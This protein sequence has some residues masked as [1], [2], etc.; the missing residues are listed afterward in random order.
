MNNPDLIRFMQDLVSNPERLMRYKQDP[1][2]YLESLDLPKDILELLLKLVTQEL[3]ISTVFSLG[4]SLQPVGSPQQ[5]DTDVGV[6]FISLEGQQ[7]EFLAPKA[8]VIIESTWGTHQPDQCQLS[9]NSYIYISPEN[10]V[11]LYLGLSY[12]N[13]N[14]PTNYHYLFDISMG[15]PVQNPVYLQGT[16]VSLSILF[17][18]VLTYNTPTWRTLGPLSDYNASSNT[19]RLTFIHPSFLEIDI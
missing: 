7:V 18:L 10:E 15:S 1:A 11:S 17:P 5:P 6:D 14:D 19:L 12:T 9:S 13:P 8:P 16:E 4:L 3:E 2:A